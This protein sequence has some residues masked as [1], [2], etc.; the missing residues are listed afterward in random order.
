[1]SKV[2]DYGDRVLRSGLTPKVSS[3]HQVNDE[4]AVLIVL[5][6]V[7]QIDDEGVV[8]LIDSVNR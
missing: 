2:P 8:N 3:K 5:E 4:E 6:R 7:A 1:M